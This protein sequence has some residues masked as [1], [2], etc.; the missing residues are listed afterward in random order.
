MP[1][2][3]KIHLKTKTGQFSAEVIENIQLSAD[4]YRI[5]L[6]SDKVAQKAFPG[7]FVSLLCKNLIL[8]RPFS[9]AWTENDTFG[10][11][12]R[13]KG[14][15]T[16]YMSELVCGDR[17]DLIGPIGNGFNIDNKKALL[18]GAGVGIAPIIF[19]SKVLEKRGIQ[20]NI[21]AGF[22]SN[23]DINE[24]NRQKTLAVTEDGSSGNKGFINDY[25]EALIIK[26]KFEKIYTCGPVPVMKFAVDMAIKH[27]IEVETAMETEFACGIGVCMGC[28]INIKENNNIVNRR[29][30]KD[31]PVFNGRVVVW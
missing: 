10:I 26:E 31:G 17:V 6:R 12:Y 23:I 24:L 13:I 4:T 25:M 11:I 3:I 18:I 19:L 15:G 5:T 21:L 8:R 14:Q 28:T 27:N 7:Q 29:I 1:D 22:R 20:Y 30:C 9:I 16:V 2:S